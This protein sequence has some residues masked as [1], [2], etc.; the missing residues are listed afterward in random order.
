[1]LGWCRISESSDSGEPAGAFGWC[2]REPLRWAMPSSGEG[3]RDGRGDPL[4]L[5][6]VTQGDD[7][8]TKTAPYVPTCL[9]TIGI[10]AHQLVLEKHKTK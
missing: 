2:G 3:L 9:S 7:A 8:P 1:M 6:C 4:T 10:V 5:A